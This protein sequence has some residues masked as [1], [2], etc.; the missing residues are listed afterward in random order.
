MSVS[1]DHFNEQVWTCDELH[2]LMGNMTEVLQRYPSC[3]QSSVAPV[4]AS[5]E[6]A[7]TVGSALRISF[8]ASTWL[9]I[10]LH[11]V[12]AEVYVRRRSLRRSI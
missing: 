5:L 11:A 8:G 9:A 7:E 1:A 6:S 2:F 4:P 3:T 10:A 12:L